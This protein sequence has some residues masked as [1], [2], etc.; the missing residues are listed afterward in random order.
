MTTARQTTTCLLGRT[1]M[2]SEK[3]CFKCGIKQSLDAFYRHPKM[4]DGHL[5]K[6][7]RCTRLDVRTNYDNNA[8][9]YRAY[10]SKRNSDP[11][12]KARNVAAFERSSKKYPDRKRAADIAAQAVRSGKLT[13]HPCFVCGESAQAHHPDYSRPLDVVWLCLP[14]H[15]QAHAIAR[16]MDA[17]S[18][19]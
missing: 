8:D 7:K 6:C 5:N 17:D 3:T 14:H 18:T 11:A 16:R 12:R 13:R 15:R 19:T 4:A 9:K 1:S 10:D 2:T